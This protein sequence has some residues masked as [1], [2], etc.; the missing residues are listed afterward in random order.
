MQEMVGGC[1]QEIYEKKV[2]SYRSISFS[3]MVSASSHCCLKALA[4]S[5]IVACFKRQKQGN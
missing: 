3:L 1:M 5:A 4:L 2:L